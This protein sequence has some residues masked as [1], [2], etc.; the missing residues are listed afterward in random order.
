MTHN[1][2]TP[3]R[4]GHLAI[5]WL[6]TG[7]MLAVSGHAQTAANERAF[8]QSKAIVEKALSQL[9]SFTSGHLPTLDGFA[10]SDNQSL[11]RF[12]RGFYQCTVQVSS[13][14]SGGSLVR[15]STKITAWYTAPVP[16]QSGYQVLGSNG[17]L[18]SDLL[19]RLEEALGHQSAANSPRAPV[20]RAPATAKRASPPASMPDAP[21]TS[22]AGQAFR[23]GTSP[24]SEKPS[25]A[26]QRAVADRHLEAL[27]T[28]AKNLGEILKNQSHPSNLVAVK[29]ADTPVLATPNEG[30]KVLFL[31][32]AEDEFEILD[33]NTNWVHVRI[34][35]LSRGWI[36]RSRLEMNGVSVPEV[37]QM[38]AT[39]SPA[40]TPAKGANTPLF[41]VE[42][43]EIASFP[44][45]WEPLRG[46]VVKIISVQPTLPTG[47]DSQAKLDFAK[48]LFEKEYS[49]LANDHTTAGVVVIFDSTDGG[50]L[51]TTLPLLRQW[52]EGS[53]SEAAMWRRCFVDPPEM[54]SGLITQ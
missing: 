47:G 27:Q 1:E 41:Q 39:P 26:T 37:A 18:E 33:L 49:E 32:A 4:L 29:Q 14:P 44:G 54:L 15:V 50:M 34:S 28:D 45:T 38:P 35:G 11:D 7:L 53:L 36:E 40:N 6:S 17:R 21:S 2:I 20:E 23:V 42:H 16:A 10:V 52:K 25:V 3:L 46:K 19:D 51:A 9:Q 30:G 5:L 12:Q 24:E 8:P 43:E 13:R 31:A 22:A 48:S